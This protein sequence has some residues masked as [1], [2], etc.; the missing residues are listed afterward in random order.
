MITEK[1]TQRL[2]WKKWPYKVI[3]G[4][5]VPPVGKKYHT[6][7]FAS[8]T[9][10][11]DQTHAIGC[12]FVRWFKK[13]YP[14][15]AM[16]REYRISVFLDSRE[17]VDH[18]IDNWR[19][20]VIEVWSPANVNVI[21]MMKDHIHDV[22]RESPWYKQFSIRA[23]IPYTHD[24]RDRG[25]EEIRQAVQ[26]IEHSWHAAGTLGRIIHFPDAPLLYSYGQPMYLYLSDN[27]D[28]VMLKLQLNEWIDRFERQRPP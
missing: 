9:V 10:K 7:Q 14:D 1:L 3:L 17:Q 19:K 23:R 4:D 16:R 13:N 15:Y 25:A 5:E 26:Q 22:I 2:F 12:N 6:M 18:V 11:E 24:V 8:R 27:E 28:A 21:K 20:H